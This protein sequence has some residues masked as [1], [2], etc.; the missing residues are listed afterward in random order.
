MKV[1][2]IIALYLLGLL[3]ITIGALL[4]IIH[5]SLFSL[6]SNLIITFG[7]I[8]QGTAIILMIYKIFTIKKFKDFLNS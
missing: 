1:K 8:F 3:F 5:H 6:N 2:H 4:K 7:S